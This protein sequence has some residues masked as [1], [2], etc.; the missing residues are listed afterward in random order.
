MR[1]VITVPDIPADPAQAAEVLRGI[2][3]DLG[4]VADAIAAE[5]G[6]ELKPGQY[7][8]TSDPETHATRLHWAAKDDQGRGYVPPAGDGEAQ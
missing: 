4:Q 3:S 8:W 2:I 7:G 1:I 6:P 5:I